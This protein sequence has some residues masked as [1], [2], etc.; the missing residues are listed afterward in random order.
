[1]E[2][3]RTSILVAF[4]LATTA[5]APTSAFAQTSSAHEYAEAQCGNG[6]Y[7]DKGYLSYEECYEAAVQYYYYITAGGGGG[8]GGG[9]GGTG[10]GNTGGGGTWI[11]DLGGVRGCASRLKCYD[12]EGEEQN[13]APPP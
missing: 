1:M 10:G 8:G 4:A 12:I 3:R 11:P 2:M 7:V 13:E 9:D 5:I 6:G